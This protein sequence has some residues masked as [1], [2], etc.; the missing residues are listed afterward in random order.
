MRLAEF[1]VP[2]HFGP[3]AILC[4][5]NCAALYDPFHKCR[6]FFI[7]NWERARVSPKIATDIGVTRQLPPDAERLHIVELD[8]QTTEVGALP[9]PPG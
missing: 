5:R 6:R 1:A 9:G 2:L 7:T 4:H 8:D 3:R